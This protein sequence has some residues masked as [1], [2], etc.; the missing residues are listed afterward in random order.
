MKFLDHVLSKEGLSPKAS[1]ITDIKKLKSAESKI[2]VLG[3][4]GV[5]G[6]YSTYIINSHL[7]AKCLYELADT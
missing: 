3:V 5:M 1:R 7:D 4:L 6:F 2:K